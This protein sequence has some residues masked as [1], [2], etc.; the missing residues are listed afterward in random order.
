VHGTLAEL[1]Q[2]VRRCGEGE[3]SHGHS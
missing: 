3:R 2:I 1:D